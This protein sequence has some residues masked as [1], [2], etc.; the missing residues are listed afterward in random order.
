VDLANSLV[1]KYD[2]DADGSIDYEEFV[3]AVVKG[4]L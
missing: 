1:L 3:N 4:E 2:F